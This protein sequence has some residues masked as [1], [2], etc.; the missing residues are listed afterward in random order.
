M[1]NV[2]RIERASAAWGDV[3]RSPGT[4]TAAAWVSRTLSSSLSL[5]GS[6]CTHTN[7]GGTSRG[8]SWVSNST[9]RVSCRLSSA[10]RASSIRWVVWS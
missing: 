3:S 7:S 8:R 4:M 6:P 1:V 9:T 10:L 5:V 2:M